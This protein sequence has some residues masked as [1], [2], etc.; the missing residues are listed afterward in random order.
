MKKSLNFRLL[1]AITI[2]VLFLFAC[3]SIPVLV[4]P[5]PP[6]P[7]ATPTPTLTAA[8]QTLTPP[9][10]DN[11][12]SQQDL[13]AT[14]AAEATMIATAGGM[15]CPR[16][17]LSFNG[18]VVCR[19][20]A[21]FDQAKHT[22]FY[23][24]LAYDPSLHNGQGGFYTL[25]YVWTNSNKCGTFK[26]GNNN[27][28]DWIHPDSTLPGACPNEAVHPGIITVVITSPGGSVKCEYLNGS[29]SGDTA[30]CVNQ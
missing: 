18:P 12:L 6:T 14:D 5:L 10:T 20:T 19:F 26:A 28:P 3:S 8:A 9:L 15:A 25:S 22:T 2:F 24:V 16:V 23:F 17:N 7:T 27:S 13:S 29:A 30:Q 11:P 21:S 1:S 4:P